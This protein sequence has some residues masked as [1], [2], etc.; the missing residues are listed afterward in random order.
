M[1]SSPLNVL[2]KGLKTLYEQ[3]KAKKG[4]LQAQLAEGKSISSQDERWLDGEANLVD[5]ERVLEVLERASNY[6]QGLEKLDEGQKGVVARLR[7][8]A[9]AGIPGKKRKRAL[10]VFI[11]VPSYD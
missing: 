7:Q 8:A 2:K 11:S 3:F 9:G 1:A 4:Q 5:E 10:L 6:E